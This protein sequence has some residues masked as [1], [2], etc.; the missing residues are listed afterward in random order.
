M[1][2]EILEPPANLCPW[3]E[4]LGVEG[5]SLSLAAQEGSKLIVAP[6][7][8][9]VTAAE[10]TCRTHG[11]CMHAPVSSKLTKAV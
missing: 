8:H 11:T 2:V 10:R 9:L 4:L 3:C 7:R 1:K 5:K 6:P